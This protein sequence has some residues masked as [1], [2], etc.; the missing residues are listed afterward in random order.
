MR[1]SVP[2]SPSARNFVATTA[3]AAA[4]LF[5]APTPAEAWISNGAA[6]GL[7]LGSLALG[8]MIGSAAAQPQ[9]YSYGYYPYGYYAPAPAYPAYYAP[10]APVYSYPGTC[11][12]AQYNGYYAC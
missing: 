2:T 4:A 9:P 3:I 7:G 5:A 10:P 1:K 8:A 11:W 6:V 12:Y